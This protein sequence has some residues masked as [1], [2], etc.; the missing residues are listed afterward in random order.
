VDV[1]VLQGE[2]SRLNEA[3]ALSIRE[4]RPFVHLKLA[5][6]LDGKIATRTGDSRW[7]SSDESRRRVHEL[8]D[9]CGAVIIG[10]AT[11]AT[12][13]PRLT[14]RLP[15]CPERH[16]LRLVLD[17]TLRIPDGLRLL[18]P[19][20]ASHTVLVCAEGVSPER[21][22]RQQSTGAEVLQVPRVS[23]GLDLPILLQHVY[24]RGVMEVLVEG[25]SETARAFL[26]AGLVDRFHLFFSPRILGGRDAVPMLGGA[27]PARV[28]QALLV[29]GLKMEPVG[30][31]L[32]VTGTPQKG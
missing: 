19:E 1:G 32:Y 13:N 4:R 7:I 3:F 14:V 18:A 26:D 17:P 11:A 15:D 23:G 31:D 22:A 30:P 8:R 12:D 2:A 24:R 25:G 9:I 10:V 20:K 29:E 6:T 16:I 5:A 28:D 27:S 21:V